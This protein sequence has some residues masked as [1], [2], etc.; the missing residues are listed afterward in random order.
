MITG[1][2]IRMARACLR[3][4][5]KD[6]AE[7]SGVSWATIQRMESADGVPSASGKN[8]EAV[9]RSLEAVGVEFTNANMPGVRLK[10]RQE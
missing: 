8:L 4:T 2:Q 10:R 1:S 9:Q 6:L 3:W 5:A 7:R